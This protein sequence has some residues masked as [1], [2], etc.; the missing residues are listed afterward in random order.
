MY[1]GSGAEIRLDK[2]H[3]M[4]MALDFT[5]VFSSCTGAKPKSTQS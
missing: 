5:K 1:I 2:E 3:G 4:P